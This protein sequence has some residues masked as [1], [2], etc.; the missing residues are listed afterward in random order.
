MEGTCTD[1]EILSGALTSAY[2]MGYSH[3]VA[4]GPS[5]RMLHPADSQGFWLYTNGWNAANRDCQ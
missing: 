3:R 2:Q 5:G 1:G 4:F